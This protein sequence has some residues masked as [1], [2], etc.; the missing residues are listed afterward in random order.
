M[1]GNAANYARPAIMPRILRPMIG[2]GLFLAEAGEWR[3]QRRLLSPSFT[4]RNVNVLLPHFSAAAA[5]LVR[6][7]E[8]RRSCNLS[9]AFQVA[10]LN[11]VLRALFSMHDRKERDR[12]G[13]LARTYVTG[14]GRPQI[15]DGFARSETSYG[16]ALWKRRAF[17][18]RWLAVIDAVVAARRIVS[19]P[20]GHRDL[21]DL[22]IATRDPETG[23]PLAAGEIRDQCATMIFA[24]Y[25][26]TARLMFW[27]SY[28]LALD[29]AVQGRVRAELAAFPPEQLATLGDLDRWPL[30]RLVLLEALRVARQS[31]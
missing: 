10:A 19:E 12:I 7:I 15:F 2:R 18:Q 14:S 22:L 5:D 1:T 13:G 27:A 28:L 3:R 30:L 29:P 17:Q 21:L 9:D 8:G 16:F 26:T 20:A 6:E 31:G 24:G 25:E 11:A 4:P 23:A